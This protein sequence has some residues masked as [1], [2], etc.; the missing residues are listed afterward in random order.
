MSSLPER[1]RAWLLAACAAML[2]G[3]Y[4]TVWT[5]YAAMHT[6]SRYQQLAPGQTAT[7]QGVSYRVLSLAQTRTLASSD[8]EDVP[9][10]ANTVFVVARVQV[11]VDDI[12]SDW[13]C[14][15]DLVGPEGRTWENYDDYVQRTLPG[16]CDS[17][18]MQSA[19]PYVYEQIYQV[20]ES[21]AGSLYGLGV[22]PYTG[23]PLMVI[24]P[25]R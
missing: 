1:A 16:Y 14:K 2:V 19:S 15:T 20:P 17:A 22:E 10:P 7:T 13:F 24:S 6:E 8:G 4:L 9:A 3:I 25:A 23:A 12:K 11:V 21:F 5:T 18:Q